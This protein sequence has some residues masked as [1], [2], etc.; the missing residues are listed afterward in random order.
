MLLNAYPGDQYVDIVGVDS[1]EN[2][3]GVDATA[4]YRLVANTIG[5]S[6]IIAL[7]EIGNFVDFQTG[8]DND[9]V[10]SF[11]MNWYTLNDFDEWSLDGNSRKLWRSTVNLPFMLSRGEFSVK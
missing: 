3:T 5:Q 6:K 10:W 9:A 2:E 4:Q 1:Y 8:K 11:F 7:S